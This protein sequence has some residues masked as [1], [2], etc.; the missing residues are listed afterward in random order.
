M[1]SKTW[2]CEGLWASIL[3]VEV[4]RYIGLRFAVLSR[5]ESIGACAFLMKLSP[6]K[7]MMNKSR[8]KI[9]DGVSVQR[10]VQTVTVRGEADK[11]TLGVSY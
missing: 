10:C 4:K 1:F 9:P 11:L 7:F 5:D 2:C 3:E 6:V 8:P